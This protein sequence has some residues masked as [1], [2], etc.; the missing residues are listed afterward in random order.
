[1]PD[2]NVEALAVCSVTLS[3]TDKGGQLLEDDL[4]KRY[5]LYISC[6]EQDPCLVDVAEREGFRGAVVPERRL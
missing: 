1:M 4:R 6:G 2:R 3:V 5:D